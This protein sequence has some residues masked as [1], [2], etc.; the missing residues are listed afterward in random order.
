[1]KRVNQ[2]N[3]AIS[4]LALLYARES[5]RMGKYVFPRDTF[6]Q[7]RIIPCYQTNTSRLDSPHISPNWTITR[8]G[9]TQKGAGRFY[10]TPILNVSCSVTYTPQR[11]HHSFQAVDLHSVCFNPKNYASLPQPSLGRI[12]SRKGQFHLIPLRA[13]IW[14]NPWLQTHIQELLLV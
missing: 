4:K 14:F 10:P 1:M 12:C 3:T 13:R 2:D 11:S 7:T 8:W 6:R 5:W 9:E